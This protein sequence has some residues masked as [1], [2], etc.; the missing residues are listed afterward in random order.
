MNLT[1]LV[2][3]GI[4][5]IFFCINLGWTQKIYSN[6]RFIL[7]LVFAV[8]LPIVMYFSSPEENKI[9]FV[10]LSLCV[11]YYLLI[12]WLIKITYKK[13]NK[14]FIDKKFIDKEFADKDFTYVLWDGDIPQVGN[15]WDTKLATK[16]TW[17][18]QLLSFLLLILP[19]LIS[20][21]LYSITKNGR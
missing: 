9:K 20:S 13:T 12:L 15:W 6:N 5:C 17:F 1:A 7:L 21:L 16:P 8:L 14:L 18:D 2:F 3:L 11:L 10:H 4:F 19:I